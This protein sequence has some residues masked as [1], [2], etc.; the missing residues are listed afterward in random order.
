MSDKHKFNSRFT[1]SQFALEIEKKEIQT[2]IES[3]GATLSKKYQGQELVMIGVLKGS[4]MFMADLIRQL[5]GVKVYVDF[6][7]LKASGRGK[8][9]EG[10]IYLA[11]DFQTNIRGKHVLVVEEIIDTGRALH[12]LKQRLALAQPASVSVVTLLDK[13][14]RRAVPVEAEF[15]GKKMNDAFV[16]GYGLDLEDY[17]RNLENIHILKFPQ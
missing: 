12:F 16:V 14:Y 7:K 11:K 1:S 5:D 3:L 10:T 8:E 15:I 17:G 6:V 13:P 9:S 2:L 4:M